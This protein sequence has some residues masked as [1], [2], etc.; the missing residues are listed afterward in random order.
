MP[1]LEDVD[2]VQGRVEPGE[3]ERPRVHVGR[4]DALGMLRGQQ[5]LD[6]AAGPEISADSTGSRTASFASVTD[7]A[8]IPATQSEEGS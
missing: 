3:G 2:V 1:E 8:W 7:G 4:D 5:R 6:P